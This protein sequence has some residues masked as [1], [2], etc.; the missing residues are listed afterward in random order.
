M[1]QRVVTTQFDVTD[2]AMFYMHMSKYAIHSP[3]SVQNIAYSRQILMTTYVTFF[4]PMWYTVTKEGCPL[5]SLLLYSI[6][7]FWHNLTYKPKFQATLTLLE[8]LTAVVITRQLKTNQ[9]NQL[10][11]KQ[12]LRCC[13]CLDRVVSDF[14]DTCLLWI[15]ASFSCTVNGPSWGWQHVISGD[16]WTA[17]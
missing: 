4:R 10:S 9:G 11:T 7:A 1:Q 16:K 15:E 3:E 17:S 5:T 6:S 13:S 14:L 12:A 8:D 2:E